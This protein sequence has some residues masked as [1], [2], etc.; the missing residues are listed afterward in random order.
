MP[1]AT[2]EPVVEALNK[3]IGQALQNPDIRRAYESTGNEVGQAMSPAE[4][5]RLYAA[6]IARYQGIAR[7]LNLRPQ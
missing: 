2:P 6:E 5:N 4:L 1:R 3:A 7:S